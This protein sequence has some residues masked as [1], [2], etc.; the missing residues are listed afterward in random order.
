MIGYSEAKRW[1]KNP[2][3][4]GKGSVEGIA[5]AEAANNAATGGA[6]VPTMVLGIPGSGTT[7][8]I[9]VGLMVHG[10]R[11]GAYLFTEQVDTVYQ[12]FGSMLL[13]NFMFMAMGLYA[14][15][16][17]ARVSLIPRPTL[18]PI[19]FALSVIGAYALA[20]IHW[21]TYLDST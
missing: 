4:F 21:L 18:W 6:M 14:A 12:I 7:A 10:L 5:G 13:A 20:A 11:P 3:E 19:V 8:I 16:L 9:L 2:E 17:F 1:S 15:K